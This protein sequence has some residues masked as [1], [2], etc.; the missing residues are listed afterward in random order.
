MRPLLPPSRF[1]L[2]AALQAWDPS[3]SSA[4]ALLHPWQTVFDPASWEQLL[5]R[6]ILPKLVVALHSLVINPHAQQ[7]EPFQW[8]IQ[9]AGAVPVNHMVTMLEAHFFPKWQQVLYQWLCAGPNFD[10]VR[11]A[12]G[13]MLLY[14]SLCFSFWLKTRPSAFACSRR[15]VSL[16]SSR[17]STSG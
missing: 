1:K 16:S 13:F 4:Y 15:T 14:I 3:D 2:G 6:S 10:E 8:F 9:W 17:C 12:A 5:V 11:G 7:L